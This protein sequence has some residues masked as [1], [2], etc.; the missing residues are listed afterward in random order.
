MIGRIVIF[1][2]F[3]LGA[4]VVGVVIGQTGGDDMVATSALDAEASKV[5]QL[6]NQVAQLEGD[7]RTAREQLQAAQAAAPPS[8]SG[9]PNAV[10]RRGSGDSSGD[11]DGGTSSTTKPKSTTTTTKSASESGS[12]GSWTTYTVKS[13]DNIWSVANNVYGDTGYWRTIAEA[14]GITSKTPLSPGRKLKIPP[15]PGSDPSSSGSS[16][17]GSSSSGSSSSGSSSSGS[18]SSGS[19]VD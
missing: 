2:T 7:L 16:S 19:S 6:E 9:D 10:N 13:G 17:S 11:D 3:L 15:R 1:A 12:T 5:S 18:S 8:T 4:F 14:N